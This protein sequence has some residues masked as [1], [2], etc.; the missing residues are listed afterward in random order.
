MKQKT[1]FENIG[2]WYRP[3]KIHIGQSLMVII[4]CSNGCF[5]NW[6]RTMVAS[7]RSVLLS[8]QVPLCCKCS[9]LMQIKY[10]MLPLQVS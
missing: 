8:W 3:Q 1:R 4:Q 5:K 9:A 6:A 2:Y 10:W 7:R